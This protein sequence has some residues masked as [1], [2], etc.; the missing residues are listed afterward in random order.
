MD[1]QFK[2]NNMFNNNNNYGQINI[3]NDNST[4]NPIYNSTNDL[5]NSKLNGIDIVKL[6]EELNSL[7]LK[8][9]EKKFYI[10]ADAVKNAIRADEKFKI[11]NFLKDAGQK[12]LDIAKKLCLLTATSAIEKS[13]S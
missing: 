10:Q 13:I 8:L 2:K 9:V 6:K 7:E 3:S 5:N 4:M 11:A 1:N 12:S